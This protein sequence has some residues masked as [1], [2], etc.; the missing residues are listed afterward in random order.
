MLLLC[1]LLPR[2]TNVCCPHRPIFHHQTPFE[3]EHLCSRPSIL[4]VCIS[5]SSY[6]RDYQLCDPFWSVSLGAKIYQCSW[7]PCM[8]SSDAWLCLGFTI[9]HA[10]DDYRGCYGIR[11]FD[12]L[13]R[14]HGQLQWNFSY[15]Q[16]DYRR[17]MD[18]HFTVNDWV[19][20]LRSHHLSECRWCIRL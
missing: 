14:A 11:Q 8:G 13:L 17:W 12:H 16:E 4:R 15:V 10:D 6:C 9:Q 5:R 20:N 1:G 2:P 3:N 18:L 7:Q 19:L